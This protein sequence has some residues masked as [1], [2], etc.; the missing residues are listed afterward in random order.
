MSRTS[1]SIKS[2]MLLAM[3]RARAL[4]NLSRVGKVF[5]E[6][7]TELVTHALWRVEQKLWPSIQN[8]SQPARTRTLYILPEVA[9]LG[10]FEIEVWAVSESMRECR[11]GQCV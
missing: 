5:A 2:I 11:L 10:K 4:D 7:I 6:P 9:R 1:M 3:V 8:G